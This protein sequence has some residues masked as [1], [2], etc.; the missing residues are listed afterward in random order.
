MGSGYGGKHTGE[1]AIEAA[2]LAKAAGKPVKVVWT[3]SEEFTWAY[4]RPAGLIEIRAAA[5]SDGTLVAWEHHNYNSGPAAIS[6]PY[7][8]ANQLIQYHETKS[9]LRQGSYRGLAST[10]N[11]FARESHMDGV[12]HA[13]G[14]DPLE[15]RLKNLTDPRLQA[16]LQAAAD[17]FGWGRMKSTPQRG[18]GIACGVDKGGYVATCA[19][20]EIDAASKR[21]RIRRVTQVWECGAI[22]NPDGLRNQLAGAIVQGIGGA[23]FERILF[24]SGR[25]LNPHFAQYRVPRF[26]DTPQIEIVLIDRKDLPS[27]GAGETG[28]VGLAPA[29]ANAIFAASGIRLRNMPMAPQSGVSGE[30]DSGL[31]G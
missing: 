17:K 10:A 5:R 20:V 14:I 2:R 8:V 31:R 4:F 1:A 16:V 18:F 24:S 7:N 15:F 21:V 6:T 27:A 25:I 22:V 9:P 19:E 11:H 23:L 13:A 12:A 26:S 30:P 29:V 3:R 28:L